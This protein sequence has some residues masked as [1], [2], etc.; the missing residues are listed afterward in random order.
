MEK[1][2]KENF[3]PIWHH[4]LFFE[5]SRSRQAIKMIGSANG[6]LVFQVI[7]WHYILVIMNS[8]EI[9]Y[10]GSYRDEVVD[11]WKKFGKE[12]FVTNTILTYTLVAE[13]TGL[14][15]ETVRRQVKKLTND[16]WVFYSKKSGIKLEPSE[17]NNKFLADTFNKKE[18]ENFALLLNVIEKKKLI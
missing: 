5:M 10:K 11:L 1:I 17:E 16:N 14:S 2:L 7:C 8:S 4:F 9:S 15:I 18:V 3:L 6:Y 13:L 12:G